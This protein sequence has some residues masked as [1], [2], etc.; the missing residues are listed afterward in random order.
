MSRITSTRDLEWWESVQQGEESP[1]DV[2]SI[3]QRPYG[4][5]SLLGWGYVGIV[6]FVV[7]PPPSKYT[8]VQLTN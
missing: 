3:T 5:I 8:G 7:D 4:E 1:D 6:R 2:L